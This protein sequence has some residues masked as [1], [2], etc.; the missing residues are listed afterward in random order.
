[1]ARRGAKPEPPQPRQS[2]ALVASA[3]PVDITSKGQ[4]DRIAKH[5]QN[6]QEEAWA[7]HDALGEVGDTLAYRANVISKVRLFAAIL[8]EEGDEDPVP[9][10]AAANPGLD[11]D[12]QPLPP[13]LTDQQARQADD[14]MARLGNGDGVPSL[15][16]KMTL[17]L[18][19]SGECHV[20]GE[21]E[22]GSER[23]GVYSDGEMVTKSGK[24]SIVEFP[25]D[26]KEIGRASY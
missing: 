14:T 20:I 7:F 5:R 16:R 13:L 25:G 8:P 10:S 12:D 19:V 3:A 15:L 1:M 6:W 9:V 2:R 4:V 22:G 21:G 23:W 26:K 11:E 18:D 17:N 24:V